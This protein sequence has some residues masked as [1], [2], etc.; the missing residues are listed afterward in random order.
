VRQA[1]PRLDPSDR[2]FNQNFEL[3][4]LCVGDGGPQVLDFNGALAHEDD[5][6]DVID[7]SHPRITNQLRI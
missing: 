3:I 2:V 4:A 5:L 7:S 6:R 1:Q